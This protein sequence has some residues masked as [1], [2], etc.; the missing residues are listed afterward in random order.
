M[1][2]TKEIEN[3]KEKNEALTVQVEYHRT[4]MAVVRAANRTLRTDLAKTA[5]TVIELEAQ[6][7]TLRATLETVQRIIGANISPQQEPSEN[8][9]LDN[10]SIRGVG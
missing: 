2:R 6:V 8:Q 9:P 3:L 1:S 7:R 4:E 10:L 5:G